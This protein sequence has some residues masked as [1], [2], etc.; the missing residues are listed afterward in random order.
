MYSFFSK[1]RYSEL[2]ADHKM[3]LGSIINYFQDCSTFQSEELNLGIDTLE[4]RH[5]AW[6]L[7]SWQVEVTRFPEVGEKI[8]VGT[9]PYA[10]KAFYG[11]RN[12]WMKDEAGLYLAKAD[13]IW[14]YLNTETGKP[15]KASKEEIT[16][17]NLEPR[18]EMDYTGRKIELPEKMEEG[19]AITVRSHHLDTNLHVNNAQ[20][21]FLAGDWLPEGF[22]PK[23]LRMEYKKAARMGDVMIPRVG[24]VEDG[25]VVALTDKEG[26]VF[27][28]AEFK[29]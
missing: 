1:V 12:F 11:Y 18:L 28:A 8:E 2:D 3:K 14:F 10:F 27:A 29:E 21:V 9:F 26:A 22:R 16:G 24:K 19:E 25:Y 7:N 20:Y 15:V 6:L 17:Y 4:G 5:R 23:R 13:S